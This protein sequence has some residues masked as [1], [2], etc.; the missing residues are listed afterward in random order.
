MLRVAVVVV[1][2]GLTGGAIG[3]ERGIDDACL[4]VAELE[5]KRGEMVIIESQSFPELSPPR[6]EIVVGQTASASSGNE[7]AD[8]IKMLDGAANG[9]DPSADTHR[10]GSLRCVFDSSTPPLRLTEYSCG[11]LGCVS[12]MSD[13]YESRLEELQVLLAREGY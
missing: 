11:M 4:R 3:Q 1:A 13:R 9:K 6:T 10:V 7:V 2:A 5:L 8:L 12:M